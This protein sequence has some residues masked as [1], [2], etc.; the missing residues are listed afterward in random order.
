LGVTAAAAA[1]ATTTDRTKMRMANF[2]MVTSFGI[3]KGRRHAPVHSNGRKFI[4]LS[5]ANSKIYRKFIEEGYFSTQKYQESRISY[6]RSYLSFPFFP[7]LL[8]W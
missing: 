2:T 6:L 1:L 8:A 7:A 4:E 3:L 5:P